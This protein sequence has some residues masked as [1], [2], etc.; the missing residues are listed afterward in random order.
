MFL[1][2]SLFLGI[3]GFL[4][5]F[6]KNLWTTILLTLGIGIQLYDKAEEEKGIVTKT[7]TRDAKGHET[8][9]TT[10]KNGKN[11]WVIKK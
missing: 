2:T 11:K 5:P 7:Y 9:T 3:P 4:F 1:P 8:T 6:L 10:I